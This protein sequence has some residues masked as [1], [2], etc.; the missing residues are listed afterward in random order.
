MLGYTGIFFCFF[1]K[2]DNFSDFQFTSLDDEDLK[3]D[4]LLKERICS[5]GS[6]FFPLRAD[7]AQEEQQKLKWQELLPMNVYP[8]T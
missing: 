3:C 7:P 5:K 1:F 2:G 8:K 6:K 4:L